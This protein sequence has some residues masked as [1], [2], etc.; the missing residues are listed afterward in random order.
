VRRLG[1]ALV[2][3]GV[4]VVGAL[5]VLTWL[6]AVLLGH[7]SAPTNWLVPLAIGAFIVILVVAIVASR[8]FGWLAAP[9][10]EIVDATER[11]ADGDLTARVTVAGPPPV[12]RLVWSFNRMADRLATAEDRRRALLA[13]VSHELRTPLTVVGGGL[14]AMLDGV[15]P[16]DAAHLEPLIEETRVLG[17][18]V[19]DLRTFS[20]SEAGALELRRERIDTADL[21]EDVAAAHEP[22]AARAG[23]VV[24]VEP[25][26]DLPSLDADPVRVREVLANLVS[27]A[28]RHTPPGGR[29]RLSATAA[30]AVIEL[31]VADTGEGIP[32]DELG[33]VFER[34]R[35][36]D[37][38][39]SGLGLAIAR[40][41]VTAHGGSITAESPGPGAGTTIRVRLPVAR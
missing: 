8:L 24:D 35:R 28:I 22:V 3:F 16:S 19:D 21:L 27:N 10:A 39:G 6:I 41:L 17:R 31:A 38:G 14:E 37:R 20:L 32:A 34:Y 30:D 13:D 12:R 36:S 5:S 40:S 7:G 25:P 11:L 23:I 1:C 9:V 2:A 29:I 15:H 26:P 4:F 18:L 33:F